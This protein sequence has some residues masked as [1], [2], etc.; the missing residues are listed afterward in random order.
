[1]IIESIKKEP[2]FG[3]W[4]TSHKVFKRLSEIEKFYEVVHDRSCGFI[5]TPITKNFINTQCVLYPSLEGTI[6]SIT[7]LIENGHINDAFALMRKYCDALIIDTYK[8]I[9]IKE[10]YNQLSNDVSWESIAN[11]KVSNWIN[12]NSPLMENR[13]VNELKRIAQTFPE[14]FSIMNL[15]PKDS[16]SL[17]ARIRSLCN[18]N[19]HYNNFLNFLWNDPNYLNYDRTSAIY[20]LNKVYSCITFLASMHFSFLYVYHPEYF[21]SIDYVDYLDFGEMPPEG[22]ERWIAPYLQDFFTNVVYPQN[23]KLGDYLISLDSMD[24]IYGTEK[25][26]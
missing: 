7:L 17:Y 2:V 5:E 12:S 22:A 3:E 11:N 20:L 13:P 18:D 8:S 19:M 25:D 14:I 24:L 16:N 6:H 15:N 4:Y 21:M 26:K 10:T 1:M 23:K 9:L